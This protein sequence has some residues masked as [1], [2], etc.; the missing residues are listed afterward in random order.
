MHL[1][2]NLIVTAIL[3]GTVGAASA[4]SNVSI[5]GIVD[6]SITGD[7][8]GAAGGVNKVSSGAASA[9]RIG[10][11]GS[12]DLGDGVSAI[13]Q[14]E[15][16]VKIDDGTLDATNTL[17]NRQAFV[18]LK[19]TTAGTV[20]LGRQYTAYHN[21]LA[22][23]AD[24]FG[25]G[26]AGGSKNLFPDS[27][28]N[29]RTSNTIMYSTP[30]FSGVT[31]DVS[32]AAGEQAGNNDAGRQFGGSIGYANG[33]LNV[34]VAYNNKNTDI[35]AIPA[36]GTVAAVPGTS[37]S[38]GHNTLVAANYDFGVIK[39][40]LGLGFDK[41]TGSAPI[42]NTNNT[43]GYRTAPTASLDGNEQ[44]I[45]LSAPV[46]TGTVLASVQ[47]KNDKTRFNQDAT[48]WGVAYLYPLS[49]RSN[50]YAAYATINNKNGA[51][52]T[53]QNNTESGTGDKG[54]N[55]GFRHMF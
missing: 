53:V 2:K 11:K 3:L 1:K 26:Y 27:G 43:F 21:A 31:A 28:T 4:Q 38:I 45:G 12:E 42:A 8:G 49:K 6:A 10:F 14:L 36:L 13:F 50:L 9:S 19:S 5:Y 33:P 35:A 41:G 40:F 15:T 37:R 25:T 16:G 52:Y 51:G 22:T 47:R 24:P 39:A 46:G 20:T 30:N 44:L 17:F 34:R 55:L 32:Y 48:G 18:G 54:Y 7:R 29:V 23:I